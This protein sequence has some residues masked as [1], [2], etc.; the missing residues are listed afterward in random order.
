MSDATVLTVGVFDMLHEGHA[1][2]FERM[3]EK[4]TPVVLVH[5]D[6]SVFDLKKR[7][8]VQTLSQRMRNIID[9][10]LVAQGDVYD[11]RSVDPS[12]WLRW[13][14]TVRKGCTFMRGDDM[15]E[16]PG[17]RTLRELGIPVELVPYSK[18]IS[19]SQRRRDECA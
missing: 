4:G 18:G 15:P 14:V 10:G 19:S 2:L 1:K 17:H 11:L 13:I 12:E 3:A 7:F 16:F 5:D 6:R 8:P 9:T